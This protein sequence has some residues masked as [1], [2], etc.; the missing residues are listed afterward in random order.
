MLSDAIAISYSRPAVDHGVQLREL[1]RRK[2]NGS[3]GKSK[4]EIGGGWLAEH[5]GGGDEVEQVVDELQ[6][7]V[8]EENFVSKVVKPGR[9]CPGASRTGRHREPRRSLPDIEGVRLRVTW[10]ERGS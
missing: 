3:R 10:S 1:G 7:D 5:V 2:E 8:G 9:R 6:G 4:L